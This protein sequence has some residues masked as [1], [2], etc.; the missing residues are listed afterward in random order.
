MSTD[1]RHFPTAGMRNDARDTRS[2]VLFRRLVDRRR[3]LRAARPGRRRVVHALGRP[4]RRSRPSAGSFLITDEWDP[5]EQQFGALVPIYGTLVTAGIAMLI[6][7]PVSFG[8]AVVP[9]RS[10]AALDARPGSARRSNCWPA[11]RPSSTAC[12]AC[13]C[14]CPY[15]GEHV[16]PWIDEH[17]GALAGHRRAV[18]RPAARHRHADRR[19]G[20]GD[21]G[22]PVHLLGDARS[23][24]DRARAA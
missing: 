24:P 18:H 22:H 19:P 16:Y 6:A 11:F 5:V 20:A 17:M 9:D 7:V 21:H 12:G 14:W 8:I 3:H 13:S 1:R 15:L 2:T 10:R 4:R 23:V